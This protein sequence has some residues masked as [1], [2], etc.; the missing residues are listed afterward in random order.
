MKYVERILE[1]LKEKEAVEQKFRKLDEKI[2]S[3]LCLKDFFEQLISGMISIFDT[4][5]I[6]VTVIEETRLAELVKKAEQTLTLK[7]RAGFIPEYEY[8]RLIPDPAAPARVSETEAFSL[9]FPESGIYPVK[10]MTLCPLKIDGETVGTLNFGDLSPSR[11][12][13]AE[14]RQILAGAALK[15]SLCLSNVA[16]HEELNLIAGSDARNNQSGRLYP[17][18]SGR[19]KNPA[20][21][22]A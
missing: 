11:F 20:K 17:I 10:S 1:K 13:S 18:D 16:A 8:S 3:T 7:A 22:T 4:P 15:I 12:A 5:Y 9:F 2:I 14:E 21:Q 6:W 19:Q